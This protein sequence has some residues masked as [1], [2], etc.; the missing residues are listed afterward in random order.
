MLKFSI[1]LYCLYSVYYA[2]LI[3]DTI[4]IIIVNYA[5]MGDN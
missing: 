4:H 5:L 1:Y 3:K 2:Y